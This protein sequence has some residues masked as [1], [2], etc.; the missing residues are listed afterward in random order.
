VATHDLS[1]P[2]GVMTHIMDVSGTYEAIFTLRHMAA[3]SRS[4][5]KGEGLHFGPDDYT[6]DEWET[7]QGQLTFLVSRA[8]I[9]VSIN[10][11]L[12]QDTLMDQSGATSLKETER[13]LGLDQGAGFGEV[14]E[15]N[16]KLSLRETCN[17]IIHATSLGLIF[18]E[19]RTGKPSA[20]Y[21]Y[22][23][24]HV[25]LSG[26]KSGAKWSATVDVDKF[27]RELENYIQCLWGD[28]EWGQQK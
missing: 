13:D 15:G 12:L 11:R 22:W 28:V 21:S 2:L 3:G 9:N 17:K 14:L 19:S 27:C 23:N 24:G 8:L 18:A 1:K 4:V 6:P 10:F 20:R 16:F 26:N 25:H 7:Y 5:C